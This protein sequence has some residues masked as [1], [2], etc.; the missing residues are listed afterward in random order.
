MTRNLSIQAI[1]VFCLLSF[2]GIGQVLRP[3]GIITGHLEGISPEVR[4][5]PTVPVTSARDFGENDRLNKQMVFNAPNPNAKS[6]DASLQSNLTNAPT[7]INAPV[8]TFDGNSGAEGGGYVPPD[9]N[10]AAGPNHVVQMIN[11]V[12]SVWNHSGIRLSGPTQLSSLTPLADNSGDPVVL[13]DQMADRWVLM[14]FAALASANAR[15][16]FCV[17]KTADPSGAYYI[18]SFNMGALGLQFPDYPHIAIWSNCYLITTHNFNAAGNAYLGGGFA[19]IDR[20]KMTAGAATTTLVQFV[21]PAEFGFLAASFEGYKAPDIVAGADPTFFHYESDEGGGPTDRLKYRT[22]HVDF[23]NPAFSTLSNW[24]YL[25]TASFDG[26]QS[27]T[28][29]AIEQNGSTAGLDDIGGHTMSRVIYRRFDTYESMVINHTVN[30]SGIT[31]PADKTEYQAAVR[32]YEVRRP[33]PATPWSIYQQSTYAP[34]G[35]GNGTS[36]I[37]GWLGCGGI[38]QRGN[39]AVGYSRS[40]SSIKPA[41]YYATR[42]I[43]DPLST[44]GAETVLFQGTGAQGTTSGNRWGDYSGMTTDPQG[45]TLWYTNEYLTSGPVAV[46]TRIG[47]FVIAPAP[48]APTIH[49]KSG[50]MF[51]IPTDANAGPTCKRYKDYTANIIIDQAPASGTT[52]N[53]TMSGSAI[54]GVDYDL[55]YT[56]PIVLSGANLNQTITVRVYDSYQNAP[57]K[58]AY[59]G[60]TLSGGTGVTTTY[61]QLFQLTIFAKTGF[62]PNSY[63]TKSYGAA[64][65]VYSENFDAMTSG[66]LPL[67]GW[68][69]SLVYL[70]EGGTNYNHFAFGTAATGFS[71]KTLYVTNNGGAA[72]AY[73]FPTNSGGT[74]VYTTARIRAESPSINLI[75]KGQVNVS[76]NWKAFGET[77]SWDFGSLRYS[78]DG[79]TNW[80]SDVTVLNGVSTVQSA[81]INLP[82]GIENISNL[83]IGFQWDCDDNTGTQPPLA[84]DNVVV[85]AKPIIYSDLSPGNPAIQSATDA[86]TAPSSYLA[87]QGT[88]YY[89][90][91]TTNKLLTK[92]TNSSSFDFGCTKVEVDRAGT[93][94]V[95]FND[96]ITAHYLASKTFK[97]TPANNNAS[98][99]YTVSLF[100]TEAEI[101]GWEA[102]TGDSRSNLKMVKVDAASVPTVT[103]ANQASYTYVI[104]PATITAFG[105]TGWIVTASFTG[106]TSPVEG[107]GIGNPIN[108]IPVSLLSFKGIYVKGQGNK[109]IWIVT[110]QVNV[111]HYELQ[112]STDGSQFAPIATVAPR[113]FNGSN[114]S[115][116]HIH[117]TYIVGNNYYRLKTVDVDGRIS[118]SNIVLINVHGNSSVVIY[119][120]PV[121][122]KLMLSYTGVNSSIQL[123]IVDALGQIVYSNRTVV[124]NPIIIPVN[125]LTSGN[126]ILRITDGEDVIN[127][128]FVKR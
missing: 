80:Y 83:K 31:P 37:N 26:S 63:L 81:S 75:G 42:L 74:T 58:Y 82:A 23:T 109:L 118:Y 35:T 59:I 99:T 20:T 2:Q 6:K 60:Y 122:D 102:T 28:R 92:I 30:V 98:A 124:A 113:Q 117:Q 3:Y 108:I 41:I 36:G 94:A 97:V 29:D 107:F 15:L 50:G 47:K 40:G 65:N 128:K 114:L 18:Y 110:N 87:P 125:T 89:L 127:T 86:A 69:E 5:L 13:Y 19:A 43:T 115:Y 61:N 77:P 52:V 39:I 53:L 56:P 121:A 85:T 25:N 49:W 64:V 100:Y 24:T 48:S 68:T 104:T 72:N 54:Q 79:G 51:A 106:T 7:N 67:G 55:I 16:V 21:D 66:L 126:Y 8:L 112:F 9:E 119:P 76:F 70:T 57:E 45:D 105:T 33:N 14:Q 78:P 11:V 93:G 10:M 17:S 27:P 88:V 90:D 34:F 4:N 44:L 116:D 12:H 101:A 84:I 71:G 103:P 123:D 95:A 91:A 111:D 62:D 1:I 38:D 120:N 73:S 46:K 96:N 32:W 22:M